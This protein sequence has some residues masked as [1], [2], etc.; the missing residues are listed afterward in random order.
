MKDTEQEYRRNN[1]VFGFLLVF[2]DW[3]VALFSDVFARAAEPT[4]A[5]VDGADPASVRMPAGL[6]WFAIDDIGIRALFDDLRQVGKQF[7]K[8]PSIVSKFQLDFL[9]PSEE[10]ATVSLIFAPRRS[11]WWLI[12]IGS[13]IHA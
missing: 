2:M 9:D 3:L 6:G 11:L 1:D 13:T 10:L 4:P 5:G 7:S 12:R 8:A